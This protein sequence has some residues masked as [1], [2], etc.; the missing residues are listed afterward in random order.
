[1]ELHTLPRES[2]MRKE[3]TTRYLKKDDLMQWRLGWRVPAATGQVQPA[4]ASARC[5]RVRWEENDVL[6]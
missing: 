3:N 4:G 6:G 1:M 2:T 5:A